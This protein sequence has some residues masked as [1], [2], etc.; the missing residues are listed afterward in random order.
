MAS[1]AQNFEPH[2]L[3]RNGH[4]MTIAAAFWRRAFALPPAE[5]RLFRVDVE[6][7]ILGHCH[8]QEGRRR[9]AP[10]VALVHGLEGSS[11][12]NYMLGIA[13]KAWTAGFHIV[14]L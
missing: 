13:E 3:L 1:L 4:L 2:P 12:S 9:D 11:D 14:R 8:W 5:E 10:V 7:Q 6:S